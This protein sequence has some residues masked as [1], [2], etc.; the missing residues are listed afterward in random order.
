M[1]DL[2]IHL[3][4]VSTEGE[5]V[6]DVFYVTRTDADGVRAKVRDP[7]AVEAIAERLR[8]ALAAAS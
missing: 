5:K 1:L 8:A 2:D 6:A 7:A 3:S 4:K